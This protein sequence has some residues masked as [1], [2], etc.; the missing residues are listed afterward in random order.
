M[1]N[2]R[3]EK[4]KIPKRHKTFLKVGLKLNVVTIYVT[5]KFYYDPVRMLMN[6]ILSVTIPSKFEVT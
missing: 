3:W 6:Q 2:L 5:L 4:M 1:L